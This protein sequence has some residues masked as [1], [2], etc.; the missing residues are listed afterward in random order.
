MDAASDREE[1]A[2]LRARLARQERLTEAS[3]A[4]HT[5]LDLREV[6]RLILRTAAEG[7]G[8]ER[9]TVFLFTDDRT[10]LWSEVV[11][12]SAP[13]EIRL[14]VGQGIAGHVAAS[15]ET[16]RVEDAYADPRFDR[17]WDERSGFRT[18]QILCAPVRNRAGEV[19]GCFQLLNKERG[20]FGPEDEAFLAGLSIHA[21]LAVEN[22][23]LHA[24]SLERERQTRE[25]EMA[26]AVQRQIQ[27][28]RRELAR[29]CIELAG[30]NELCEDAS[31]DYYD[32]LPELSGG[33]LCIA[34]GD[35]CGH[36]LQAALL[37]ATARALLRALLPH[38]AS[39][40]EA[41]RLMNEHLV[42]DLDDGKFLSLFT[43][44]VDPVSGGVEWCNAG[45]CPPLYYSAST[46]ELRALRS[47]GPVLGVMGGFE[48]AAGEPFTLAPGD[49]LFV[50]TDGATEARSASGELLGDERMRA[51]YARHAGLA[52]AELL[53]ALRAELRAW[54]GG[55]ANEDDLT[56]VALR[57]TE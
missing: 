43:A 37:M 42:L 3:Y 38:A 4:L 13:I 57:R 8:A 56:L 21:A 23:R 33:R 45:H 16:I 44:C 30:L 5:S 34:V 11:S 9:G 14:P 19:V 24:Q 52:P 35:V 41:M 15:G 27:P 1:I 7:V 53:D 17:S 31:G 36:G 28:E 12:G 26:L 32:F 25:I 48:Y 10:Q 49:G 18:R 55:S 2:E 40:M 47:T 22:A 54:T 39:A 6:L 51:L 20:A 46:G 29:G 50:F